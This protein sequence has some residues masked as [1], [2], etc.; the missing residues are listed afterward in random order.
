VTQPAGI[1]LIRGCHSRERGNLSAGSNARHCPQVQDS[2]F[3]GN[4]RR[5]GRHCAQGYLSATEV[6]QPTPFPPLRLC[7][8]RLAS[9]RECIR[10]SVTELKRGTPRFRPERA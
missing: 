2:R 6:T 10:F 8:S 9:G 1:S 7:S 3:H 4:D 5:E